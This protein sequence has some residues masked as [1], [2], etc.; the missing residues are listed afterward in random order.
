[1]VGGSFL[2]GSVWP[3]FVCGGKEAM[4]VLLWFSRPITLVSRRVYVAGCV[5]LAVAC[6][7][8]YAGALSDCGLAASGVYKHLSGLV[9]FQ[10]HM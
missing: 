1:M 7:A 9:Q 10:S 8:W 5:S 6:D 4:S 3:E 2:G